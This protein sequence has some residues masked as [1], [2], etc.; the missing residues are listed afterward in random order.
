M[1]KIIVAVGEYIPE[2]GFPIGKDGGMAWHRPEDLKWFRETTEHNVVV[3]GRNTY[4]AIGEKPLPNR[5]N[6]IVSTTMDI[7]PTGFDGILK[8][9]EDIV[10]LARQRIDDVY[11]IG[12]AE[13]YKAAIEADIVD[14]I[15]IDNISVDVPDADAFFQPLDNNIWIIDGDPIGLPDKPDTIATCCITKF[16]HA[17][18]N[19]NVDIQYFDLVRD[20]LYNGETKE[21]R[22]GLTR[23]VFG[24]QLRFDLRRGLP[25]L[26]TKKVYT[27]GI[28]HELIWFLRGDTNIKYLV[29]NNVHIWDDDAYRHYLEL[30]GK[31]NKV[32]DM[33][34]QMLGEITKEE[35]LENVRNGKQVWVHYDEA[36]KYMSFYPNRFCDIYTFGDLGPVYGKQWRSFDGVDQIRNVIETLRTNPDDRRMLVS[37][38]NV[39]DLDNMALPPCHYA[40]QFYTKKMNIVER[41][42]WAAD[43]N[44]NCWDEKSLDENNVPSRKLSCMFHIRSNDVGCGTSFNWASYALLTYMVAQCCNM[45]ADEL[46][47]DVGDAHIYENHI[48]QLY[49]QLERNPHKYALPRVELNPNV[50]EINDFRACDINIV[51]YKSYPPIKL[52]LNV[53]LKN[54]N[55]E[56]N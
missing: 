50:K 40:F 44:L 47:Y 46:I 11:I 13:L 12:G 5:D 22:A 7:V 35:F 20:I 8:N 43:N 31:N 37:A 32:V 26:T 21:T 28:I 52:E 45:V 55:G 18:F 38:W 24:R 53:G 25:L 34:D 49:S 14:E 30:V 33:E 39:S 16:K 48:K 9:I 54:D 1:I 2:K 4:K 56:A 41:M 23:S 15:L 10:E 17:K 51:G 19:N 36:Y 3:M 27:N 6:F 29:D 42:N